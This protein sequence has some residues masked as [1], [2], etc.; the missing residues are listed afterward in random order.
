MG[1][2]VNHLN[3]AFEVVFFDYP[4]IESYNDETGQWEPTDEPEDFD[5][6][7]DGIR[8]SIKSEFPEYTDC[9]RWEGREVRIFLE[10]YGTEIAISEY[11]GLASLSIRIDESVLEYLSGDFETWEET[12]EAEQA[13]RE[14]IEKWMSENVSRIFAGYGEYTKVGTFSNGE[15]IY[16]KK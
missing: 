12:E 5:C 7:L 10:G 2:S 4:T 8:E 6:V 1:R 15:S 11:C 13:E 16:T 9:K 3:D 14:R